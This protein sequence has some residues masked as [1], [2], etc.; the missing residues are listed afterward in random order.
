MG[1]TEI[2]NFLSDL[3]AV[4]KVSA[5][6]QRQA[7]NAIIF[8]YRHVLDITISDQLEPVR[9]SRKSRPPVV[10]T[11]QEVQRVL[12]YVNANHLLM[13]KLLYGCG[14]CLNK[15]IRLRVHHIDFERDLISI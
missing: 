15:C 13:V 7:L 14:L 5:A 4:K 10:M 8:L 9:A 3:A 6:T 11:K 2:D 12:T 1:K